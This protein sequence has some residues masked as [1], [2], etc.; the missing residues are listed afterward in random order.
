M[1]N[2]RRILPLALLTLLVVTACN[3]ESGTKV[4]TT[5]TVKE[6]VAQE[7][8]AA[9]NEGESDIPVFRYGAN[10]KCDLLKSAERRQ[11]CEMQIN[12][13]IGSMLES[14]IISGFDISRCSELPNA[15]GQNCQKRLTESGVK[16]P[17]PAE[18]VM[19]FNEIQRGTFSEDPENPM[20]VYDSARCAELKAVGYKEYCEKR[21]AERA[22]RNK[23]EE[24]IMS[25]DR[26]RCDELS[27]EESKNE[28]RRFFGIEAA[29][30]V[31]N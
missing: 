3:K 23:F 15:I 5:V 27:A 6:P 30:E 2:L 9:V 17:V 21:V 28:C 22:E 25:N 20:P 16:G 18:E 13:I 29:E 24:V 4:P 14:E 26:S 19:I 7:Q 12:E 10:M 8:P 11:E 1:K 31:T